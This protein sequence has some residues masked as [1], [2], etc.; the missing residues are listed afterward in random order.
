MY[1]LTNGKII[2]EEGIIEG[3]DI[4][5]EN[6]IIKKICK[7]G[8]VDS[9]EIE[10]INAYGGFISP[11]FIDIHADYIE[12][13]SSPRP[14]SIMD[15]NLSLRET[16]KVLI[17]TGITT[18]YHS[19]SLYGKDIFENKPIRSDENVI[20]L[21][22]TIE[23]TQNKRHLIRHRFHARFEIDNVKGVERLKKYIRDGKINLL[24]FM[25]HTP[26]QG[27]Y[28]NI[29]TYRKTLKGYKD[30]T[31]SEID[32]MI[33]ERQFKD[34]I[35]SETIEEIAH[36]AKDRNISIA[37]HDDDSFDKI[38]FIKRIG[39]TIS[40]FPITM[41]VAKYAR[42]KGMFTIAGAPN[43][44]LGKSHSGNLSA[45]EAI[46]DNCIDIL[47]SDYY[48]AAM[49]HSVFILNEKYNMDLCEMF[50]LITINPAKAVKIDNILGSI[51]EGK[52]ADILII[53]KLEELPVI[54]SVFVDG[55][56]M[57]KINYRM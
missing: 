28:R 22:D 10:V 6:D 48:P 16:E 41:D 50:K 1:L 8:E 20:K 21:I 14:T 46:K 35:T 33:E 32:E 26:G 27:Q 40:E 56:L 49:L 39:A 34:T 18:M 2:T 42:E 3:Y 9:D 12:N 53:E 51:K 36:M 5:I 24:S 4:L 7:N 15:F 54:T 37:S 13:M 52:K 23:N 30:V 29:E 38:D 47:C 55:K 25:D 45:S 43:V 11:G 31:D 57:S 17:N 19:L 44:L